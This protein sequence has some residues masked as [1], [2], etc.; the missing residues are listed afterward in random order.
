LGCE[1]EKLMMII[2][3]Q[4]GTLNGKGKRRFFFLK[5]I[6]TGSVRSEMI[7]ASTSFLCENHYF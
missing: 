1:N 6:Y 4:T 3:I 5:K 7:S 2:I